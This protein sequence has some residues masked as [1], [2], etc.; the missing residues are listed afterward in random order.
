MRAASPGGTFATDVQTGKNESTKC[1]LPDPDA[2]TLCELKGV[3]EHIKSNDDPALERFAKA[4]VGYPIPIDQ[5]SVR[6]GRRVKNILSLVCELELEDTVHITSLDFWIATQAHL[7]AIAENACRLM[8]GKA[9]VRPQHME[10]YTTLLQDM[11]RA[12]VKTVAWHH[13]RQVLAVVHR[14]DS[15]HIYDVV[16]ERWFPRP[17]LGLNHP[18]QRDVTCAVWNPHGAPILAVGSKYGVCLWRL[19]F[20]QTGFQQGGDA[21]FDRDTVPALF[22][23]VH[24]GYAWMNFLRVPGFENITSLAWS[25]DGQYLAMGSGT[26]SAIIIWDVAAEVPT[27]IS[28]PCKGTAELEWSPDGMFLIQACTTHRLIIWETRTWEG[29]SLPTQHG[30]PH[31]VCWMPDSKMFM[32]AMEGS[33]QISV[34]QMNSPPPHLECKDVYTLPVPMRISRTSAG[35]VL[36]VGGVIKR[37]SFDPTG[38]RLALAFEGDH[39]GAELVYLLAVRTRPLPKFQPLGYIRGPKWNPREPQPQPPRSPFRQE[40]DAAE[41]GNTRITTTSNWE[42]SPQYQRPVER[43]GSNAPPLPMALDF[44]PQFGRGALLTVVWENGRIGCVPLYIG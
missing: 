14:Q 31:S 44:H 3:L 15:V 30:R 1:S 12:P 35:T 9:N 23:E 16:A 5:T 40:V 6:G 33:D 8:N 43:S 38:E 42:A 11:Q 32:F 28:R 18:Y 19:L 10:Y 17:T 7:K 22:D 24:P 2:V 4:G 29:K 34:W 26:N 13:S 36:K 27:S 20:E 25:P 39:L 41:R 37:M 21:N